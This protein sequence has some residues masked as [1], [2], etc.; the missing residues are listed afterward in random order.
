MGYVDDKNKGGEGR[1]KVQGLIRGKTYVS[2]IVISR[3][4]IALLFL[5][6]LL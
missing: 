2:S 5:S 1:V 3:L 4:M 6:V